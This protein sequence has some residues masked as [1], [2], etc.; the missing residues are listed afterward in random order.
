[1][2]DVQKITRITTAHMPVKR[3]FKDGSTRG[4]RG[5]TDDSPC[6]SARPSNR[7]KMN[8]DLY[9]TKHYRALPVAGS[10][11]D[12]SIYSDGLGIIGVDIVLVGIDSDTFT[13]YKVISRALKA[14]GSELGWWAKAALGKARWTTGN[15]V[16]LTASRA[17][18]AERSYIK[19]EKTRQAS[20]MA[21]AQA[22]IAAGHEPASALRAAGL[23][24]DDLH[25]AI[26]YSAFFSPGVAP[27][28]NGIS[29]DRQLVPVQT[30]TNDDASPLL[31]CWASRSKVK[32][33]H[34]VQTY[35]KKAI[36]ASTGKG[37]T[38]PGHEVRAPRA[39]QKTDFFCLSLT[40]TSCSS[41][42]LQDMNWLVFL[43]LTPLPTSSR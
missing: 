22:A 7:P 6:S 24:G 39:F 28:Q 3:K 31:H 5:R 41:L 12:S 21:V 29:V 11:R 33:L 40:S 27:V 16:D 37:T 10:Y 42:F 32:S 2:T 8:N 1:M 34:H 9:C 35:K 17:K 25:L 13:R 18:D 15:Q 30:S 20:Y 36:K 14:G 19:S 43:F 4:C 26:P 23:V 38:Y